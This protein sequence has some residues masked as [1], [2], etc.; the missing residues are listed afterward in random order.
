MSKGTNQKG[1]NRLSRV[2][3]VKAGNTASAGLVDVVGKAIAL[4]ARHQL[5]KITKY[6]GCV[7]P[8][9]ADR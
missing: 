6:T 3:E 5:V 4:T 1:A 7:S 8:E 9:P 2:R